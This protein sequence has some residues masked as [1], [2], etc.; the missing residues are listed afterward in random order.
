M[1]F[2][3]F[4][5]FFSVLSTYYFIRED[6]KAWFISLIAIILNSYLYLQKGI[7]AHMSL[8]AFYFFTTI[9]G[10]FNWQ[11]KIHVKKLTKSNKLQHGGTDNIYSQTIKKEIITHI[12]KDNII[13]II[14]SSIAGYI[15]VYYILTKYTNSQVPAI[16]SLS[17]I[18]SLVAQWLMCHKIIYT[19]IFWLI[20]DSL[21]LILYIGKDLPF[22]VILMVAY[23][24]M[25]IAGYFSWQKSKNILRSVDI[26]C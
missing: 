5:A 1:F 19:W 14:T 21:Y 12:S 24:F 25:A 10:I 2:D 16:D 17:T 20:T 6:I 15:I 26:S 9:Y 8:E 11:R 4:G 13:R 23:I 3:L 18:T 22:H 7:Y